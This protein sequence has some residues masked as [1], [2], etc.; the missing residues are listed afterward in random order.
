L[1]RPGA[2]DR[3]V[4]NERDNHSCAHVKHIKDLEKELVEELE[5]LFVEF[6]QS[7]QKEF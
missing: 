2:H 7:V 5:E 4:A 6:T 1:L 3:I